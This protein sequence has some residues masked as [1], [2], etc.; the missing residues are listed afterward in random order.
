M[1]VRDLEKS[2]LPAMLAIHNDAVLT[3]TAIWDDAPSSLNERAA[4]LGAKRAHGLPVLACEEDGEL[5]GYAS[6]GPFRPWAGYRLTV[7][8][9][10]YVA[11]TQRRRG[12]ARLLVS[13]LVDAARTRGVHVM[14]AGIE[15]GNEPSRALHAALGFEVAGT[16]REVGMKF[17]R[18]LDLTFMVLPLACSI[19]E[20]GL[21]D[22]LADTGSRL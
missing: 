18:W 8:H 12:V 1:L 19:A 6:F 20:A 13:A 5:L 16:L 10:V 17:G 3:T 11:Q 2:D 4:W 14:V 22:K 9:S 21:S 7:E 15:G